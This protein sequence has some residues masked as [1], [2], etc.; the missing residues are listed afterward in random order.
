MLYINSDGS[1]I[2]GK[3]IITNNTMY[4]GVRYLLH[5]LNGPA[6]ITSY[7]KD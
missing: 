7:S 2:Y 4:N 5:R 6:Y 1:I 3:Q